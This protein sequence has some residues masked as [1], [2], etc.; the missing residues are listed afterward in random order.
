MVPLLQ[1]TIQTSSFILELIIIQE[2]DILHTTF[3][4]KCNARDVQ[5]T[6]HFSLLVHSGKHNIKTMYRD[7]LHC[8]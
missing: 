1:S 5:Q 6:G 4:E 2:A 3:K 7:I 8:I